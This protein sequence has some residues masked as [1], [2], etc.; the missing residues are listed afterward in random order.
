MIE[1]CRP[2]TTNVAQNTFLILLR[3]RLR[4]ADEPIAFVCL[5]SVGLLPASKPSE[6]KM[7]IKLRVTETYGE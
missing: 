7:Q 2:V 6:V 5:N 3:Y 1:V 4:T